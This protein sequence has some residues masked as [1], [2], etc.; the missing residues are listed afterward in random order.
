[1]PLER[2]IRCD[3][4]GQKVEMKEIPTVLRSKL[5][6]RCLKSARLT[7]R[8]R[9]GQDASNEKRVGRHL[10]QSPSASRFQAKSQETVD[11]PGL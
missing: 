7:T 1:M 8:H 2:G 3:A 9:S 11:T 10:A 5:Q 4:S 6:G